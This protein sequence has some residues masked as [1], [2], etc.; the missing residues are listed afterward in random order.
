MLKKSN[1]KFNLY[2][3]KRTQESYF[4]L[5]LESSTKQGDE[6]FMYSKNNFH[7]SLGGNV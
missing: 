4:F 5:C 6:Y 7:T 1:L 2:S 3:F